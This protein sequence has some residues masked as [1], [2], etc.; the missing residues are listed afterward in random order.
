MAVE[1]SSPRQSIMQQY[2]A[3]VDPDSGVAGDGRRAFFTQALIV[4][5]TNVLLD[6][7]RYTPDAR[8]Q[9]LDALELVSSRLWLPYQVGLEFV[10]GRRGVI[11]DRTDKLRKAKS[12]LDQPLRE[13]WKDVQEALKGVKAL[14][15]TF[16]ADEAGQA[17][18]DELI[19]ETNF[20]KLLE[21]WRQALYEHIDK[22]RTSQDIGLDDVSGGSDPIL[23]K[24]TALYGDKLG[25]APDPDKLQAQVEHAIAYRFPNKIPPGYLDLG[26]PTSLQAA[27]DY[28]LWEE[29]IKHVQE[30]PAR[31]RVLFVSADVKDDWYEPAGVGSDSRRP[32]PALINEFHRRTNADLLIVE[33]KVFFEGVSEFLNAEITAET[34]DEISRTADSREDTGSE[35]DQ[36]ITATEAATLPPPEALPLLA[37]RAARLSSP[38]IRTAIA[39]S[40]HRLFQWWLVGVTLE[41]S[42]RDPEVNEPAVDLVAVITGDLPPAPDWL[43]GTILPRGEFPTPSSRWI[44]PWLAQIIRNSPRADRSSLLRLAQRQL[45]QRERADSAAGF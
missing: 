36:V 5:D 30:T 11:E 3:W 31:E 6:L 26:K 43:P 27:G 42:L 18:L 33:T 14:L 22:L 21:P 44:A 9:V 1:A 37:Y 38:A 16:A 2:Q 15:G 35:L 23:P 45:A 25:P 20:K 29:M 28:I 13:A 39:D 4:L 41:L 32:W 24:V 17:E 34:V 7:Y 40:R 10:R 12:R 19:N 8:R